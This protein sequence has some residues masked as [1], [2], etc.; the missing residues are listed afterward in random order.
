M[1]DKKTTK[2]VKEE[3]VYNPLKNEEVTVRLIL[4]KRG[5][6]DDPRNPLY[7]GLAETSQIVFTVPR[8]RNGSLVR[9]FDDNE[10]SFFEQYLGLPEGA[11]SVYKPTDNYWDSSKENCVNSVVLTKIDTHLHLNKWEDY[12]KYKILLANTNLICPST[13]DLEDNPKNTYMFVLVNEDQEA[14]ATGRQADTKYET[15]ESFGNY[16]DSANALR[17]IIYLYEHK[18]VSSNTKIELLKAKVLSLLERDVVR[19]HEILTDKLLEYKV[20]ICTG[21]EKGIIS[22]IN[23]FYYIKEDHSPLANP[24]SD[25]KLNNAAAYIADPKNQDLLFSL[26]KQIR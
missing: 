7:G 14:A 2:K 25:S 18:R 1:E 16:K 10:E 21:V 3:P 13:K 26:Q 9:I 23:G 6:V 15:Y 22:E 5:F 12:F 4:K 8:D 17:T 24:G 19:M 20:I 11:L